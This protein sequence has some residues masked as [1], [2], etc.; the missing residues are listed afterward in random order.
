[1]KKKNLLKIGAFVLVASTLAG[2]G[3][4]NPPGKSYTDEDGRKIY[5][6]NYNMY[7]QGDT[8][9]PETN[10]NEFDNML[11]DDFGIVFNY[12]RI[13]R[14]DWETK[15]NT[16]FATNDAP[17]ITTGGKETNYKGW[18]NQQ[19]LAPVADSYEDLC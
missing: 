5:T 17:D 3:G 9:Y 11:Y 18:A 1:M 2:C 15:T 14:T 10:D 16:Y 4:I 13:A 12:D 19:M 8:T 7:I 6:Y